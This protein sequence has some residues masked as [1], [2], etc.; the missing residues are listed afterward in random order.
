MDK[1]KAF[2][3]AER[4]RGFVLCKGPIILKKYLPDCR[5]GERILFNK[6]PSPDGTLGI[7]LLLKKDRFSIDS[8]ILNPLEKRITEILIFEESLEKIKNETNSSR[9]Q[10]KFEEF[11]EKIL[12]KEFGSKVRNVDRE[13]M[14]EYDFKIENA[15]LSVT[16]E[17]K[18]DKWKSTGNISLELLRDYRKRNDENIGSILKTEATFWQVYYYDE[19]KDEVSSEMFLVSQLKYETCKVLLKLKR[20][21]NLI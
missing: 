4:I 13:H 14:N 9:L 16:V 18:S 21:L 11:T 3:I 7:F 12:R 15:T 2:A 19:K 17:V 6:Y 8:S 1:K 5:N 20:K 10:D